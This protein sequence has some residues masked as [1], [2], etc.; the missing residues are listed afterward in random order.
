MVGPVR[1]LTRRKNESEAPGF[2]HHGQID[3][4]VEMRRGSLLS[5]GDSSQ[6]RSNATPPY[7][8]TGRAQDESQRKWTPGPSP[9][10]PPVNSA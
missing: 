9:V 1:I 10:H 3:T 8:E 2:T 6:E 7:T 4:P 5:A